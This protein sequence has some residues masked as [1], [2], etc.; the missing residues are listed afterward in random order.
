MSQIVKNNTGGG[1]GGGINTIT[2]NDAVPESPIANNFNIVTANSTFKFTGSSGTETLNF[3]TNNM[4]IGTSLPAITT[5]VS[6]VVFGPFSAGIALTGG[7]DNILIGSQ[8]GEKITIGTDNVFIGSSAAENSSSTSQSIGIGTAALSG[9]STGTSTDGNIAIGYTALGNLTSGVRNI[10]IGYGV[11]N[12]TGA[13]SSNILI[14]S[15]GVGSESNVMRLGT[16]G[17][18]TQQQSKTFVAGISG[19]TVAA[20]APVAVASTGQLSSLGFGTSGQVLTSTG[21]SSSPTWQAGGG[22]FTP[23]NWSVKLSAN[24]SN[25]TGDGTIYNIIYNTVTFDTA[26]GYSTGTGLYTFPTTGVYQINVLD[27]IFGGSSSNTVF[28]GFLLVNGSTNYRLM[29]AN[30]A[31]L[32]LTANGEFMSS[33]TFLYSATAGDTMGVNIDVNGGSKNVGVAGGIESCIFSGFR[34]A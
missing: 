2:G 9:Y 7:D 13:E 29:D 11:T 3:N 18:G 20:S 19:T 17:T 6:N 16:S 10:A 14:G 33:A 28:L 12:Y 26:S 31:T 8:T 1:G 21:A 32:G 34:V 15:L 5:G 27:F 22:G 23:V 24:I 30:P 4:A 25:V